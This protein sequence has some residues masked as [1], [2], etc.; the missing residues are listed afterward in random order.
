MPM[1]NQL[2]RDAVNSLTAV[3]NENLPIKGNEREALLDALGVLS[4][5]LYEPE[6]D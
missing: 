6:A 1:A 3:L 2:V 4:E 5:Y